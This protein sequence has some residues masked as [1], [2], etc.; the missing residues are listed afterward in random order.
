[1]DS[2][3]RILLFGG[4]FNPIHIGHLV[5]AQEA[6]ERLQFN[7]IVFI[8]SATPPHKEDVLSFAHRLKMTQLSTNS[9]DC[10]SVSDIESKR[11]GP[12]Y[13][14]D[15]VRHFKEK[16]EGNTEIYW[17]I[18]TDTIPELKAWYKIKELVKECKF[19][20]AERNPYKFYTKDSKDLFCF[21]SEE[22]KSFLD[23]DW[24]SHFTPL[25]NS[26]LEISSTNIRTRI[27][28]KESIKFL[29]TEKV[30][31]YIYDNQLYSSR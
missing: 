7:E 9:T 5:M 19:V 27:Q 4:T 30:E 3:S 16:Y 29:V 26:I 10:F 13:T 20:L 14:I 11:D 21:L 28:N 22:T 24:I 17:L 23:R 18:G 6:S 15:T 8:P 12:S 31:Q 25:I 1:M 2:S